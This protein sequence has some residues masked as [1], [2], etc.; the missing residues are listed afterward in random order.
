LPGKTIGGKPVRPGMESRLAGERESKHEGRCRQTEKVK[1]RRLEKK[2]EEGGNRKVVP[3]T[4]CNGHGQR[5]KAGFCRATKLPLRNAGLGK[6]QSVWGQHRTG[7]LGHGLEKRGNEEKRKTKDR[8]CKNRDTVT[9][10]TLPRL[11]GKKSASHKRRGST[12]R[13]VKKCEGRLRHK[14]DQ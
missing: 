13:D 2:G 6:E 9:R 14:V 12:R 8:S 4:Y 11:G 5:G 1:I 3:S 10:E 7:G